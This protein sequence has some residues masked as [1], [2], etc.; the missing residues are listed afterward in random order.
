MA[1]LI[2]RVEGNDGQIELLDD[3]VV[4]YR[5]GFLNIFKYGFNSKREIPLGAISEVAFKT[6]SL[7]GMGQIEFIRSGSNF[8]N[9]AKKQQASQTIVK[10]N[11]KKK[12][13]FETLK[14]K[15]FEMINKQRKI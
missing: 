4:I 9:N 13:E 6:P 15:V 11:G 7:L 12:S 5:A 14:E 8:N 10:F 2:M 3:R 1:N